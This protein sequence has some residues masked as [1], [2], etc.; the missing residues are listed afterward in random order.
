MSDAS[1]KIDLEEVSG[2]H[3]VT[4][5]GALDSAS[6]PEYKEAF[7]QIHKPRGVKILM[8]LAGLTYINST[9]LGHI[10]QTHRYCMLNDGWF[11]VCEV[12]DKIKKNFELLGMGS[13]LRWYNS[14]DEA[15][16]EIPS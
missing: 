2:V 16:A 11:S 7:S 3:I 8:N 9:G 13:Q 1:F 10:L 5:I 6:F 15:L 4:L 12:P 14:R